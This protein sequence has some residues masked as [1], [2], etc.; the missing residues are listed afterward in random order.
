[1][2]KTVQVPLS[3]FVLADDLNSSGLEVITTC[4]PHNFGYVKSL[5][6]DLILDYTSPDVGKKIREH[7]N[8]KLFYAYDTIGEKSSPQICADALSTEKQPNGEKPQ[9][10]II[11]RG[12]L[13][14]ND[15]TQHHTF[16]STAIG[17][18]FEKGG[19]TFVGNKEDFEHSKIVWA[20]AEQLLEAKKFKPH[21]YEVRSGGL[22]G[23]LSGLEDMKNGK[24]SGKKI[25]YRIYDPQHPS[26]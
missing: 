17:E 16:G 25:V 18:S 13:P 3:C 8:N 15:V 26:L 5:G 23:I 10:C 2:G 14:R 11:T 12:S 9:Y 6:A 7:T 4:S 24:V 19:G 20:K 22:D 21:R 1:V